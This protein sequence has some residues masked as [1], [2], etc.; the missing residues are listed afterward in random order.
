MNILAKCCGGIG[1][2]LYLVG[3]LALLA[4]GSLAASSIYFASATGHAVQ[5]LY[6]RSLV[7]VVDAAEL[8]LLIEKHRRVIEAAPLEFDRG[9]LRKDRRAAEELKTRIERLVSNSG[10]AL[11]ARIQ[12]PLVVVFNEGREVLV[13][14]NEFAQQKALESVERYTT[15]AD[16]LHHQIRAHRAERLAVADAEMTS[17]F[18]TKRQLTAWV[19]GI[20]CLTLVFI[21]PLSL[22]LVRGIAS[23]LKAIT[24]AMSR[25][26][27]N[28]TTVT[29]AGL[30]DLD[31]IGEMARSVEVFKSNAILLLDHKDRLE[32]LNLWLDIAL[33]NMARGLSM[34]DAAHRLVVCN[35]NYARMYA[36]PDELTRPGTPFQSILSRRL[37]HQIALGSADAETERK[38]FEAAMHDRIRARTESRFTQC[39]LDGRV[40][41][42]SVKPLDSGGWVA[43]HEDVTELRQAAENISRLARHDALTGLANRLLFREELDK[44]S[45]GIR[46]GSR[47]AL[48]CIDLDK[49][50][51]VND[52]H[53]HPT[54]DALLKAVA[55]RLR[56]AVRRG[57]VVA[58]LGGDEFAIIQHG[59]ETD[60]D[61]ETLG[62]RLIS[63]VSRA[64]QLQGHRI[65]IG[66]T[67]G[68]SI[69]AETS[70]APDDLLRNA[71]MALYR[72]KEEGRG[73][74]RFYDPAM[75]GRLR[76]RRGLEL[77]LQRALRENQFELHYQPIV[78]LARGEVAGCEALIRWR[79]PER[80]MIS[81]ADFIPVAEEMGLITPIGEWALRTACS[82]AVTW[83]GEVKVAVNL[84]AVQFG[85][86]DLVDVASKALLASG[87][88]PKR[89]ELEV[90]ESVLLD[91]DPAMLDVLHGLRGLGIQIALDDFGTGYSS[92]SYLRNFP[93]DKIKIDQ[94]FVRDLSERQDCIAIVGAVAQL[95]RSLDMATVAEG[96]ETEDHLAKVRAAGCTEVQGYLLSRPVPAGAIVDA[97]EACN[98]KL[99]AASAAAAA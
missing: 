34:F 21:G 26:A 63:A 37:D 53:G 28:E 89:L 94:T 62:N 44:A 91:D 8:E 19:I 95:A 18:R 64:Y 98:R 39:L 7:A 76:A 61:A 42:V 72:A 48:H 71:D 23:R 84:S 86:C 16:A 33:N 40:I 74:V 35:A 11:S 78:N 1:C 81:P 82:A 55:D 56:E 75:E 25:L 5:T 10:P 88:K 9:Q 6:D 80:G 65:E 67:I 24:E 51:E 31:E 4:L 20:A 38:H 47:F 58:R 97:I 96:V 99:S 27:L 49:F 77:D 79:H 46:H 68:I 83:P 45:A 93:F 14:A 66:A 22:I 43:V 30:T 15:A 90:T 73:R 3:A 29:V 60:S 57:D 41:D 32:K 70:V 12:D 52:A 69:A 85:A 13:L 54:G 87:L 92:L 50:K 36:L 17:L 2:R 59:I